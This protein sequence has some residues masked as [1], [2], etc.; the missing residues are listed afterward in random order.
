MGKADQ[1]LGL[2]G[3]D[4]YQ[5]VPR[6]LCFIFHQEELLLLRGATG[7]RLWA[8]LYNGIGGHVQPGEDVATSAQREIWEET[9]LDV[10]QLRL[11]GVVTIDVSPEKGVGL[12]VFSAQAQCRAATP[13]SEGRLFWFPVDALPPEE[14]MVSDLPSLLHKVIFGSVLDPPFVAH[15]SYDDQDNLVIHFWE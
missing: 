11:A 2:A 5:L 15:F 4:R 13:S 6:T 14:E 10:E 7:K 9:G 8:G 1:G 12:Y 3:G